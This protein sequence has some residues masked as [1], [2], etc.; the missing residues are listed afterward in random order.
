MRRPKSHTS[1][2]RVLPRASTAQCI[3]RIACTNLFRMHQNQSAFSAKMMPNISAPAKFKMLRLSTMRPARPTR[4]RTIDTVT[5]QAVWCLMTCSITIVVRVQAKI[6]HS[7][8]IKISVARRCHNPVAPC[9]SAAPGFAKLMHLLWSSAIAPHPSCTRPDMDPRLSKPPCVVFNAVSKIPLLSL[10]MP[11]C[12][13]GV[14][15]TGVSHVS[16]KECTRYISDKRS[17][18]HSDCTSDQS[19]S[20]HATAVAFSLVIAAGSSPCKVCI[21]VTTLSRTSCHLASLNRSP[22]CSPRLVAT[23]PHITPTCCSTA[24]RTSCMAASTTS[25]GTSPG[26]ILWT[27]ERTS[28]RASATLWFRLAQSPASLCVTGQTAEELPLSNFRK[29]ARVSLL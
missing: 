14:C 28:L 29:F 2:P 17:C 9:V 7:S 21:G 20:W 25:T 10:N 12:C 26:A 6:S 11:H 18:S 23:L 8:S 24:A 3:K 1:T 5:T 16:V 22:Q 27:L 4:F 13:P 19:V 15:S